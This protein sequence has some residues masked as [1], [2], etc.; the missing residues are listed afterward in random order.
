MVKTFRKSFF[1]ATETWYVVLGTPVNHSMFKWLPWSDLD[2]FNGNVGFGN[3]DFSMGKSENSGNF[4]SIAASD[5]KF[6][7]CRQLIAS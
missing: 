4:K 2:L 7:R 5:L 1:S 3:L 6:G